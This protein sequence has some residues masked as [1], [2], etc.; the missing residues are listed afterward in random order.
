MMVGTGTDRSLYASKLLERRWLSNNTFELRL[1]RPDA[2]SFKPGQYLQFV[3]GEVERAYTLIS[4]ESDPDLGLCVFN[5]KEGALTPTLA[6]A[7][8][9]TSFSF[10]GPHGYFTFR[11]STRPVV[12]VATGVGI[13]PYLSMARS[14]VTG[15]TLLHGVGTAA[16]LYYEPFFR[17]VTSL[18]VPCLSGGEDA[19]AERPD[20]FPG[21]VTRYLEEYLPRRPCDFY[22]CGRQEMTHDATLL[23]DDLFPGSL[24]F[25]EIF[26]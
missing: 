23:V 13:A 25:T 17:S 12:F 6:S 11:P 20:A 4:A 7:P 16:D 8:V 3:H 24:V 9:G 2:F 14:G 10:S 26:F 1:E 21:R 18:Y 22:L 19:A 15:F 5:A